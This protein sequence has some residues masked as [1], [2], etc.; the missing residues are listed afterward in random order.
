MTTTMQT[1]RTPKDVLIISAITLSI[2]LMFPLLAVTG[3]ALQFGFVIAV[4][5]AVL[6]LLLVPVLQKFRSPERTVG[7][8]A[9]GSRGTSIC[10]SATA[11][12]GAHAEDA[13]RWGQTRCW[14]TP[15]RR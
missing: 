10:T 3:L 5:L 1:H 9:L 11:G 13:T 7:S 2:I 8:R 12:P 14:R 4:P 15:S 6:A